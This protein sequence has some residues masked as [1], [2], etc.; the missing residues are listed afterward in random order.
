MKIKNV[1]LQGKQKSERHNGAQAPLKVVCRVTFIEEFCE[2]CTT[3]EEGNQEVGIISSSYYVSSV[4]I[5]SPHLLLFLDGQAGTKVG[6]HQL[7][8]PVRVGSTR[9]D[10][11]RHRPPFER[12]VTRKLG[13]SNM[14]Y[15]IIRNPSYQRVLRLMKLRIQMMTS[16]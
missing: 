16:H 4:Y 6:P 5:I 13:N 9:I 7:G 11:D 8:P 1:A 10:S 3:M 15:Y 14:L 2:V 12:H